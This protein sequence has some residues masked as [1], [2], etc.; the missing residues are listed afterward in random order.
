MYDPFHRNPQYCHA[1]NEC[2]WELKKLAAHFHP[3]V[4]LFAKQI[5][6]VSGF[7][8]SANFS[9]QSNCEL[10]KS[11]SFSRAKIHG[12]PSRVVLY[13]QQLLQYI[14]IHVHDKFPMYK[15]II[16]ATVSL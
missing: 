11:N 7:S 9:M 5:L 4:S 13:A 3:S 6:K 8:S 15:K 1:E 16:Y 10:G 2:I 14:D 12:M